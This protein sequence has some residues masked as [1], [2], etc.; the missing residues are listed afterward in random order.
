MIDQI[1]RSPVGVEQRRRIGID[2]ELVIQSMKDILQVY[3]PVLGHFAA[4]RS[5]ADHLT[6]AESA[7]RQEEERRR[8]PVISTG[9]AVDPRRATELAGHHDGRVVQHAVGI[10][11]FDQR[12]HLPGKTRQLAAHGVEVVAVSLPAADGEGHTTHTHFDQ[13]ASFQ[14]VAASAVMGDKPR[15]LVARVKRSCWV[16][17]IMKLLA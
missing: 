3:G 15:V 8:R 4:S 17:A 6:M 11:I 13:T 7:T 1:L 5:R 2:R 10:Q 14:E 9:T 16:V 12:G